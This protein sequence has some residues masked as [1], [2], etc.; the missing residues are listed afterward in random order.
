MTTPTS[1]KQRP[2]SLSCTVDFPDDLSHGPYTPQVLDRAMLTMK[3]MGVRRVFW[4]HYDE[5]RTKSAGYGRATYEAIGEPVAAAVRVAH[6]HGMELFAGLKPYHG[7]NAGFRPEGSPEAQE[8]GVPCIGGTLWHIRDFLKRAPHTR[9]RRRPGP[10]LPEGQT[11]SIRKIRLLKQD[12]SPTRLRKEHLEVWTSSNNYG[13]ERRD[14]PFEV[15]ERVEPSPREVRDYYGGLV[16]PRGAPVRTLTLVGLDLSDKYILITTS[17]K[18]DAGDFRNT[19]MG[20]IEAYG[21]GAESLPISVAGRLAVYF[22]PRDFRSGGLEFDSGLG[23]FVFG[24]DE[25]NQADGS[26]S[27]RLGGSRPAGGFIAF[28]RGVNEY[29]PCTPCEAY[30]EVQQLW[31]EWV[32]SMIDAG[33]DGIDFRL[34]DH[35][36]LTDEPFEYG[37][38]EP[39]LDEYRRKHG[40]DPTD[41]PADLAR[42]AEIRGGH[43]TSF[44]REASAR[45]RRAGKKMHVHLHA[46]AFRPDPSQ[47]QLMGFPANIHFDWRTWLTEGLVD[48][49]TLR[50]SWW[51]GLEDPPESV[52]PNRSRLS[53]TLSDPVVEEMLAVAKQR[54]VPVHLNRYVHRVVGIDEYVSDIEA[55]YNDPRFAAFDLYE[56]ANIARATPHGDGL[57][58]FQGRLERI[59][60]KVRELGLA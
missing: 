11:A 39:I 56:L 31:L 38:N 5:I 59:Q 20:M 34:S 42:V 2:F 10:S 4:N 35:G 53:N 51:E 30:P 55:V 16:T 22:M 15:T 57:V 46:E 18:D 41:H 12:D 40:A 49:A 47:G 45:V 28:A 23:H 44:M 33:V 29:L 58:S 8:G 9:I 54:G 14:V 37:F 19:A 13:Y 27:D 48:S 50:T 52:E 1:V 7:G 25:S 21:E 43:Y 26:R 32:D 17:S 24:L 3:S 6:K 36:S 60:A